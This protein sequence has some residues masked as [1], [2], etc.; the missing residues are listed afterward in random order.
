[1]LIKY[2]FINVSP[3]QLMAINIY[4]HAYMPPCVRTYTYACTY[5]IYT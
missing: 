1:M 3:Q 4:I 2:E 5:I